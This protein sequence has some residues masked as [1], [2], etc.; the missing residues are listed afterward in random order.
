MESRKILQHIFGLHDRTRPCDMKSVTANRHPNRHHFQGLT[1]RLHPFL[2]RQAPKFRSFYFCFRFGSQ[3]KALQ[4]ETGAKLSARFRHLSFSD[5][6]VL[7]RSKA[8][9]YHTFPTP[10]RSEIGS[11]RNV[12][13]GTKKNEGETSTKL[14]SSCLQLPK[15]W[16]P[17][18]GLAHSGA[19][20]GTWLEFSVAY[21]VERDDDERGIRIRMALEIGDLH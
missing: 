6:T 3:W 2:R 11:T 13:W 1:S 9:L 8:P 12:L 19:D 18:L 7:E 16:E 21:V 4:R 10:G 17:Y 14:T 15:R 5:R 20:P